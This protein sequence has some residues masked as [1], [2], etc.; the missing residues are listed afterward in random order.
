M[1]GRNQTSLAD[2][3]DLEASA[4]RLGSPYMKTVG[5]NGLDSAP[6]LVTWDRRFIFANDILPDGE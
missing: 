3:P 4:R 6:A 1:R 2:T 5:T